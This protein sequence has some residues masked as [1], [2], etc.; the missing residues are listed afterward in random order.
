MKYKLI[1]LDLDGTLKNSHNEITKKTRDALIEVQ[2]QGIKIVLASGRPTPGLR[3]EAKE[4]E[5]EKYGG[6]ILSFN[7]AQVTNVKT[8]ETIYEQTL[9]IE[10]AKK[11][12]DRS[13]EFHLACMTYKDDV[14]LTEDIDDEYVCVE[15][16]INDIQKQHVSSFVD[17]L[18]DP[19]HKVLLTGKPDYMASIEEEFKQPFGDSLSIYRSAPFF[20]EVM[21]QGIDKAASLDRL[22]QSLG[23]QQSE[24]MAFGDGYNDLSM[25][26]YAGLG[27]AM[28][29]A[30]DGVKER[31]NVITKSNDED[32]IA[33]ILSQ[34]YE[35]VNI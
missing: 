15:A 17:C 21:A 27:V 16:K 13:Q 2:K 3:H 20:I 5:L 19:I 25:I 11:A 6:Y 14:I 22:A 29:N 1:A 8:G 30:V 28:A 4:L 34:E 31:A 32:G 24:V 23:I 33:Y 35:G 26:E 10:E 12:Y 18:S 7:G 9:T